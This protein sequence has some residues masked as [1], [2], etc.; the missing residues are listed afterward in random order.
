MYKYEYMAGR[1]WKR[2]TLGKRRQ[3]QEP[4]VIY[5]NYL[6]MGTT[7]GKG[8]DVVVH[9][10]ILDEKLVFLIWNLCK[11]N[12]QHVRELQLSRRI[13]RQG[14][15]DIPQAAPGV[16][17][18]PGE[19]RPSAHT[20]GCSRSSSTPRWDKAIGTYLR[21][22]QEFIYSQVRQGYWDIPHSAPGVHL[23]PGETR[24]IG[25]YS[26]SDSS[27]SSSTPRWDK[28]NGTYL[29]QLQDFIYSRSGYGTYT[30]R[31]IEDLLKLSSNI[32]NFTSNTVYSIYSRT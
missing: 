12:C 29:S 10:V 27:R 28:D 17:L 9:S 23:L 4:L 22:L 14:H 26:T 24:L 16:H 8:R 2:S 30:P 21:L 5:K 31:K 1:A 19:T 15:R 25:T 6:L 32:L 18:L 20:S 13:S 7:K 3:L 11:G